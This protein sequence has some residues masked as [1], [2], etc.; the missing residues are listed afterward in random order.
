[1]PDLYTL[2]GWASAELFV[3][4]LKA[5]GPHPTRGAVMAQLKKITNFNANGLFGGSDP[6]AK[7]LTPLLPDGRHQERQYVR[8]L[9]TA[10]AS[11][12]TRSLYDA[13]GDH[14]L[15][16]ASAV[17][18]LGVV[19]RGEAVSV[20]LSFTVLGI[21]FGAIYG[22]LAIGLVV[23]Y[24]TTGVFNFAQGAVGM[25]AA[26]SY[27]E[28]WQD[29]HWP[30]LLAIVVHRLRRGAAP[31][32]RGR[33]RALPPHPRGHGRAVAHGVARPPGDPAR[34][35]H[36][37]LEQPRRHP[38]RA[39]LLHPV[40]RHR[41]VGPPLRGQRRHPPV[42]AD[43]DRGRGG[44]G[45]RR[46]SASSCAGP[47]SAWPCAPWSTTPSWS[48]WPAPSRTGMSQ[49]G[50]VL[51]LHAGRPGRRAHRPARRADRV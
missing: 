28:L 36:H 40:R 3:Q 25:V 39:A 5:A 49:M 10:A 31:G 12:A 48:P 24:N 4:A 44:G 43:H 47:G 51:G 30:F 37:L 16:P 26:F 46:R 34:R 1:M 23:T 8:E 19:R 9:P 17:G 6:A 11:T 42:P 15:R 20:F 18:V 50:W 22:I 14:G 27:W 38:L 29:G 32:P 21:V 41:A 33:V 35:G 13:S 7:K 2:F 45:R